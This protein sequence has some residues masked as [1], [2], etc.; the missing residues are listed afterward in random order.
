MI[1]EAAH[2]LSHRGMILY[3]MTLAKGNLLLKD[4]IES[5]LHRFGDQVFRGGHQLIV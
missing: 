3:W 5:H 4:L 2:Y 1:G